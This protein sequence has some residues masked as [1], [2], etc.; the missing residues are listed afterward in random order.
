MS[1]LQSVASAIC[2]R[3]ARPDMVPDTPLHEVAPAKDIEAS[4]NTARPTCL[5]QLPWMASGNLPDIRPNR[6][7]FANIVHQNNQLSDVELGKC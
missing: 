2:E 7:P 1:R 5:R 6:T 3:N 4:G